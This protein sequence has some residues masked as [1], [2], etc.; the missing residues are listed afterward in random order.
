M[1]PMSPA[2]VA[3]SSRPSSNSGRNRGFADF[4]NSRNTRRMVQVHVSC[5]RDNWVGGFR[6]TRSASRKSLSPH[7]SMSSIAGNIFAR[8]VRSPASATFR[9]VAGGILGGFDAGRNSLNRA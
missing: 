1:L 8:M 5:S 7:R 2:A 4:R 9:A 6:R 3:T